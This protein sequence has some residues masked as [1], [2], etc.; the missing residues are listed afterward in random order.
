VAVTNPIT[1]PLD[2]SWS[3]REKEQWRDLAKEV[4]NS[5]NYLNK[6]CG[7]NIGGAFVFESFRGRFIAGQY[8]GVDYLPNYSSAPFN[9]LTDICGETD[10]EKN[11]VRRKITGIVISWSNAAASSFSVSGTLIYATVNPRDATGS[12]AYQ[13]RVNQGIRNYL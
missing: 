9:A 1:I 3:L 4:Q 13:Y 10:V 12:G 2:N 8:A 5:I 6:A 11:S 7:T